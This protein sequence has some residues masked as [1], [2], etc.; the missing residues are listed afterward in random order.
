VK[1][2]QFTLFVLTMALGLTIVLD[3]CS[4]APASSEA[5]SVAP[6]TVV[7]SFYNWYLGYPGNTIVDGAYRSSEYLT[8]EFVRKVDEIIASFDKGGYD[9][10]LCAQDIPESFTVDKATV[11]GEEASV[12]VHEIWNPGTQYESVHNVTVALRM[13]DGQWKIADVICLAPE[14]VVVVPAEGRP[15][16][17]T[18]TQLLTNEQHGYCLLYPTGYDVQHPNE[19]ETVLFIGSLLNVEQPR[20]YIKVQEAGGS[21][22]AQVADELTVALAGFDIK[23]TS[24]TIDGEAAVVLDNMPGQDTNRQVVIVHDDRLYMLP[25]VPASEDYGELYAQM[26]NLYIVVLNSFNFSVPRSVTLGAGNDGF[27]A[28]P[29]PANLQWS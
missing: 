6:E 24:V 10:F 13:V 18:G 2:K 7:E 4:P 23:R 22:A 1:Q 16:A 12:V 11:S 27:A 20:V 26:E 19:H 28:G 14:P 17:T 3:R 9:P 5:M 21:T 25:F 8:T 15:N 29:R